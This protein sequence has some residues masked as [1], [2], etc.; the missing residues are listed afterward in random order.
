LAVFV[1]RVSWA[2]ATSPHLRF[3]AKRH[4]CEPVFLAVFYSGKNLQ[5]TAQKKTKKLPQRDFLKEIF[6][7]RFPRGDFHGFVYSFC[8]QN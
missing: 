8:Q 2:I 3:T 6:S 4:Y 1:E 5:K 7:K